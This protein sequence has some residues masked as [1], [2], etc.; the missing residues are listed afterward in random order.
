[1]ST[2]IGNGKSMLEDEQNRTSISGD[3]VELRKSQKCDSYRKNADDQ[4]HREFYHPEEPPPLDM[5]KF[6]NFHQ[7][8]S[9]LFWI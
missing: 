4:L 8:F 1:M 3:M 9:S 7:V 2:I 5:W 6:T